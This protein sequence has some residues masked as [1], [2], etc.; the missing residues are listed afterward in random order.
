MRSAARAAAWAFAAACLAQASAA[1]ACRCPPPTAARAFRTADAVVLARVEAASGEGSFRR[2]VLAVER[3]WK[4][5]R[6]ARLEIRGGIGAC[7]AEFAVGRAY[8]IYL[9]LDRNGAPITSGTCAGNLPA[10]EAGARIEAL[11]RPLS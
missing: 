9:H 5:R 11:G 1:V 6:P 10:E 3:S 8:L 2:Y 4:R 7:A